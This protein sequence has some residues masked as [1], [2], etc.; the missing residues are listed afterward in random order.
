VGHREALV[1]IVVPV[2]VAVAA[3]VIAVVLAPLP[4]FA[5]LLLPAA[6]V[7]HVLVVAFAF[8]L[9]VV[10]F[11]DGAVG[12][13]VGTAVHRATHYE[14]YGQSGAEEGADGFLHL[15]DLFM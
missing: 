11:F 10:G 1:V 12:L 14:R 6:L 4:V 8:P 9:A 2:V 15:G 5:L 3:V 13:D 7:L